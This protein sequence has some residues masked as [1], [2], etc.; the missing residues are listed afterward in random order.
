MFFNLVL[1]NS[2]IAQHG[3]SGYLLILS[4]SS[5][6]QATLLTERSESKPSNY[7]LGLDFRSP[8]FKSNIHLCGLG[9]SLGLKPSG[10]PHSDLG[11]F[12]KYA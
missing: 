2:L 4:R 9:E 6:D 5:L 11:A 1:K 12:D 7:V 10:E 3:Q 8:K